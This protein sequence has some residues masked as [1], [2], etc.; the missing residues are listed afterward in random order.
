MELLQPALTYYPD[1]V[2]S[3]PSGGVGSA[4]TLPVD[5]PDRTIERLREAV[6]EITGVPVMQPE[7]RRIGFL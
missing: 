1:D 4:S 7:P 3:R 5:D 6:R 2:A